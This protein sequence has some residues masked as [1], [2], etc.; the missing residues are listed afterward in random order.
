MEAIPYLTQL[1]KRDSGHSLAYTDA[2]IRIH[3]EMPEAFAVGN[4]DTTAIRGIRG[5]LR[6]S[7][8]SV[9]VDAIT[10]GSVSG[11]VSLNEL[12]EALEGL[13]EEERQKIFH[14]ITQKFLDRDVF[15]ESGTAK[16]EEIQKTIPEMRDKSE[17]P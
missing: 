2:L 3:R 7:P 10:S 11:R 13:P 9:P 6:Y 8:L 5:L 15:E 16:K 1:L 12:S 4:L 17:S 14:S